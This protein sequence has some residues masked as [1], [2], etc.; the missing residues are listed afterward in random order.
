[1]QCALRDAARNA[2]T[3]CQ[4]RM[5]ADANVVADLDLIVELLRL[6]DDVFA[7]CAR[8]SISC[9]AEFRHSAPTSPRPAA[10]FGSMRRARAQSQSH[11]CR[12]PPQNGPALGDRVVTRSSSVTR[13]TSRTILGTLAPAADEAVRANGM[14]AHRWQ[15]L[16]PMT[17]RCCDVGNWV[18]TAR[19]RRQ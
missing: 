17:A 14:R 3:G 13:A 16:P 8:D 10:D 15:R 2:H 11:H 9:C 7:D 12:A 5:R 6:L 19:Q 1:M 18:S 4:H